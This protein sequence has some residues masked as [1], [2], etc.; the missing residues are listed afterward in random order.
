MTLLALN[1]ESKAIA[2]IARKALQQE[3]PE[4]DAIDS[5]EIALKALQENTAALEGH[6]DEAGQV[7]AFPKDQR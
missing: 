3:L 6:L 2:Q 7:L 5:I 1:L 4:K